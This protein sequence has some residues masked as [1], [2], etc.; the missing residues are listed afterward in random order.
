MK[1]PLI[2]LGTTSYIKPA[3]ILPNVRYLGDKVDDIELVLF[4]SEEAS[5]LPDRPTIE[6]LTALQAEHQ[7]SYT[8]HFPLDIYPGSRDEQVRRT[9]VDTLVKIVELTEALT[10]FGYVLHL[11][12]DRYGESPSEDLAAWQEALDRSVSEFLVRVDTSPSLICAETL[13]YPFS[14][15]EGIVERHG[16]SVTLD[17][18]HIWLMGYDSE[19]ALASLLP[20]SRICHLHG[21]ADGAD[22]LG[23]DKGDPVAIETFL[24]ALVAQV[25]TDQKERVLT[26][27][28]FG[29]AE[30]DAS[31]ALL[32]KSCAMMRAK[33]G[34]IYGDH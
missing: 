14:L 8:V 28:V 27:E 23:L 31:K 2:R 18:G 26:M 17:I 12:P 15:V 21:V 5:N 34:G 30:F 3:D 13:S 22:H 9:S 20:K 33:E 16:L 10:P 4:E 1:G 19:A 24:A 11:S 32:A 6:A 29:E 25:E 7:L